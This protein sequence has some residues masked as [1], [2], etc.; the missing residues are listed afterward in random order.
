MNGNIRLRD[1]QGSHVVPD[2]TVPPLVGGRELFQEV[3]YNYKQKSWLEGKVLGH[4]RSHRHLTYLE[5]PAPPKGSISVQLG[6]KE[7]TK[8][9]EEKRGEKTLSTMSGAPISD[10]PSSNLPNNAS[11]GGFSGS[12]EA[13]GEDEKKGAQVGSEGQETVA[14]QNGPGTTVLGCVVP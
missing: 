1:A 6:Q 10:D 11:G 3:Q 12:D 2:A 13:K 4:Y 7:R 8:K 14:P 5:V 9:N